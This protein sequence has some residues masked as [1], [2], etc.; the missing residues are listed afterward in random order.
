M[1][2]P[3]VTDLKQ[4]CAATHEVFAAASARTL[5]LLVEVES[6]IQKELRGSLLHQLQVE[7]QAQEKYLTARQELLLL[8]QERV[9][10]S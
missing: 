5:Q 4:K 8:V 10:R 9:R 2:A 1:P 6:P 7:H 3:S